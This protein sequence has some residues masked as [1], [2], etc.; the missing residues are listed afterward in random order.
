VKNNMNSTDRIIR[1]VIAVLFGFLILTNTVSGV[2]AIILGVIAAIFIITAAIGICPLY[3]LLSWST[4]K[5]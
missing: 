3:T 4:K 2:L 1:V 5:L